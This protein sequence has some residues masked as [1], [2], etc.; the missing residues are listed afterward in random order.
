VSV[1]ATFWDEGDEL[2]AAC[3]GGL[4]LIVIVFLSI[5]A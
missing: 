4:K 1:I 3:D 5:A 2:V